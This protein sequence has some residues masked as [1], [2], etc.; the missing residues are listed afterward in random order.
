MIFRIT[1]RCGSGFYHCE[2]GKCL[3]QH[4]LC[5]GE[6]H[7]DFADDEKN[8]SR[9]YGN[10]YLCPEENICIEESAVCNQVEDC[11]DGSDEE[12]CS[13]NTCEEGYFTCEKNRCLQP[14]FV[15]DGTKD[16]LKG[17]DE[18]AC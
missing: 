13:N 18:I 7:C 2:D 15:C 4:F 3:P 12:K 11:I 6:K 16:C 8:C 1:E 14:H 10:S 5:D 9:C 17:E